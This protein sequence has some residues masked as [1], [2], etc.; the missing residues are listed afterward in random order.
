MRKVPPTRQHPERVR[1]EL[2]EPPRDDAS[3]T[4]R[5]ASRR[6]AAQLDCHGRAARRLPVRPRQ[7]VRRWLL[8]LRIALAAPPLGQFA[9]EFGHNCSSARLEAPRTALFAWQQQQQQQQQ[10]PHNKWLMGQSRCWA[11]SSPNLPPCR[12]IAS[13]WPVDEQVCTVRA[14]TSPLAG[15]HQKRRGSP[16]L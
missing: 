4:L 9:R 5:M 13:G 16:R 1:V 2:K 14:H 3:R 8:L 15:R 7:L 10:Q 11:S 12:A 6:E